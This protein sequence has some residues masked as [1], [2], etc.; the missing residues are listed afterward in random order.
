LC[1]KSA[2]FSAVVGGN[3]DFRNG[4]AGAAQGLPL[5]ASK[6]CARSMLD[7]AQTL[8]FGFALGFVISAIISNVF[9]L[10]TN[11]QSVTDFRVTSD[12]RRLAIIG[13]L[14]LA[15]PHIL[16]S[17]AHKSMRIGDW[18]AAYVAGCF[19]LCVLWAFILGFCVLRLFLG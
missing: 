5:S 19:A 8:I 4:T 10:V 9:Q 3:P 15:G 16:F 14:I 18:P 1:R 13:L 12:A 17:A 7:S 2:Q 6:G 11:G